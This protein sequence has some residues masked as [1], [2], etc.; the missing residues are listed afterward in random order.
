MKQKLYE[1][2]EI[3]VIPMLYHED[4]C[5]NTSVTGNAPQYDVDLYDPEWDDEA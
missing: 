1:T 2:P 4:V 3:L 5:Q